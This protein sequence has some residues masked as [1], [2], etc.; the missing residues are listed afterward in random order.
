MERKEG[1]RSLSNA[2]GRR[3]RCHLHQRCCLGGSAGLDDEVFNALIER[4]FIVLI[5]YEGR[6]K[7]YTSFACIPT[8]FD[9][10]IN[11]LKGT[12]DEVAPVVLED[13]RI[14]LPDCGNIYAAGDFVLGPR[15]VVE[16]VASAR[17][18]VD[19]I[20]NRFNV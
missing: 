12:A 13:G 10:L 16:A 1:C 7:A 17:T 4:G 20:L 8:A 2:S 15:T 3:D 9:N 11:A 19:A 18:A 5:I 14:D 6:T